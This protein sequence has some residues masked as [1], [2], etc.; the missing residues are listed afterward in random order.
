MVSASFLFDSKAWNRQVLL[1][2]AQM[3]EAES[4]ACL[5]GV[6]LAA[7]MRKAGEAVAHTVAERWKPCRTVVLCGPGNNGGDG[8]IAAEILRRAGWNVTVAAIHAPSPSAEA[9]QAAQEWQGETRSLTLEVFK[10]ADLVVDALFGTGLT[11]PLTGIAAESVVF[12]NE[13]KLP[14]LAVDLPSGVH[15]DSGSIL[16]VAVQAY[17]TVS[18]FRKKRA[19]ILRPAASCCGDIVVADIGIPE[20]VLKDVDIETAQNNK[21]LWIHLIPVPQAED[22]KYTKGHALVY[23]GAV[24]TGAGRLAARAAQRVGAGLVTLAV[25]E[26]AVSLYASALESVI[27]R[28]APTSETWRALAKDPKRNVLLIGPGMG[29]EA[30][31]KDFVLEVLATRKPCVL[32]ADAL[33]IFAED[34]LVL[35]NAL[36]PDVVLTPHEGEFARLFG[37]FIDGSADKLTRTRQ[38]AART[39]CVVLLKG[40][41]TMMAHPDGKAVINTNAPPWLATAGSGDVLAGMIAGLCAQKIPVFEAAAAS[42]WMHGRSADAYGPGM[43]AED[44]VAGIPSVLKELFFSPEHK[45]S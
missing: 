9:R 41:E 18:F 3:R 39:G 10:D 15:T 35:F 43:I 31:Y 32:D 13:R 12:L 17:V 21:D 24:M 20:D 7:M 42:A 6:S 40:A 4:L 11:R 28:A 33:T 27:V 45:P 16:G 34:P 2:A 25:P 14:V 26:E 36:H 37:S 8:Y 29:L 19:H 38:A 1:S 30:A 44:I 22:H 5:R 23:G